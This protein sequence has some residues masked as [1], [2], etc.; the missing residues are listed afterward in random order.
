MPSQTVFTEQ[1]GR[2]LTVRLDN[3]PRNFLG[4]QTVE[5]LHTLMRRLEQDRSVGAVVLTGAAPDIFV[6]HAD[7]HEVLRRSRQVTYSPSYRQARALVHLIGAATRMPGAP[8]ALRRTPLAG[9]AALQR[10]DSTFLRMNRLDK[11]L[12]AAINGLALGG[13]CTLALA[14]DIRVMA[15]G[16]HAI[17]LPESNLGVVAAGGAQRLA[18][19]LGPGR[20]FELLLE[21]RIL[22]PREAAEVGLV[23]HIVPAAELL[24]RAHDIAQRLSRRSPLVVRE[25]KRAVYDAGARRLGAGTRLEEASMLATASTP[26]AIRAMEA[27]LAELGPLESAANDR[28]LAAWEHL[29]EGKLV[30]FAGNGSASSATADVAERLH[31]QKEHL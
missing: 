15:E 20:A 27:Y 30:D 7:S 4:S 6:T 14:C 19:L 2:V 11:V 16:N 25:L 1:S 17:G 5:E 3:P 10:A 28:V 13:G 26:T 22:G 23:H 12:I 24:P 8:A 31:E 29:R 9:I 21:G 18:R